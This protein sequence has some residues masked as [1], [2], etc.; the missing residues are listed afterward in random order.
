LLLVLLKT[1]G[2]Y[3]CVVYSTASYQVFLVKLL[4]SAHSK[5]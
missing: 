1:F 3:T 5:D 2:R 4:F